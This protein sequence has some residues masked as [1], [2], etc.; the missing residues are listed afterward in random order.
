MCSVRLARGMAA[1]LLWKEKFRRAVYIETQAWL[2]AFVIAKHYGST[3]KRHCIHIGNRNVDAIEK[4]N[5]IR[6]SHIRIPL[7]HRRRAP[8]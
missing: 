7:S 2:H 5:G 8:Q 3:Y 4:Y 1:E 6:I